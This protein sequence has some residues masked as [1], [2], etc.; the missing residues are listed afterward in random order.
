MSRKLCPKISCREFRAKISRYY[1]SRIRDPTAKISRYYLSR[2]RDPK[3]KNGRIFAVPNSGSKSTIPKKWPHFCGPEFGIQT[4][5][6]FIKKTLRFSGNGRKG[7]R[8]SPSTR[9]WCAPPL[10]PYAQN[11]PCIATVHQSQSP[12][13]SPQY[14][15][16]NLTFRM[17]C[18]PS[19]SASC[20]SLCSQ[21]PRQRA[22][23]NTLP[24]LYSLIYRALIAHNNCASLSIGPVRSHLTS[25]CILL[26][27]LHS[28][29]PHIS[30]K[31]SPPRKIH[32]RIR[33]VLA[34]SVDAAKDRAVPAELRQ[35]DH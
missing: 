35:R 28:Q 4:R 7:E 15:R 34:Q 23:S 14:L 2:V 33:S 13:V 29:T 26:H 24:F 21:R 5:H 6:D 27:A 19:C 12:C 3:A 20:S 32:G 9:R 11:I 10:P 31:R 25:S 16:H 18:S 1:L 22:R 8:G 30:S 17:F